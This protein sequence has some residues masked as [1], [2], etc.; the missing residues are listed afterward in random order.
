MRISLVLL[1]G[2]GGGPQATPTRLIVSGDGFA[3]V[4]AG[5]R[6]AV[7]NVNSVVG[8]Q[9][10]NSHPLCLFLGDDK[11]V[12]PQPALIGGLLNFPSTQ[13]FEFLGG[14]SL[15]VHLHL[16]GIILNN[17]EITESMDSTYIV[18]GLYYAHSLGELCL[19]TYLKCVIHKAE[20]AHHI[21]Y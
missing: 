8:F 21:I 12:E 18:R 17:L 4:M 20:I 10:P 13:V 14:H 2:T 5:N 3:P 6:N 9:E 11:L 19:S 7:M 16:L 1:V 15:R